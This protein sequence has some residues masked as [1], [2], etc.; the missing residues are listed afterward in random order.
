MTILPTSMP[1]AMRLNLLEYNGPTTRMQLADI[2][3]AILANRARVTD[4]ADEEAQADGL[5]LAEISFSALGGEI[6][7]DYPNAKPYPACLIYGQTG[8]GEP[9]HSVWA[10]NENSR[11]AVPITVYRPEP[12]RWVDWRR[13]R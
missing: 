1:P 8:D 9:V 7:E 12:G 2:Q 13:R 5:T 4:H 10:Y 11:W 3:E 6:V